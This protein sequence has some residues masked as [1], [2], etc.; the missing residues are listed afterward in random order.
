VGE[1]SGS[2]GGGELLIE[3]LLRVIDEG[4][5][6][7]TYKLALLAG[8]IDAVAMSP[9]ATSIPTRLVAERVLTLYYPQ[10][11]TYV[12]GDGVARDLRQI[13]MK[14]SP[15][16]RQV[17]RLR[18]AADTARCRTLDEA[19]TR[20]PIYD[21]VLD[22]VESTFVRYPIPLLQ[23][24]GAVVVPFLYEVDA[25]TLPGKRRVDVVGAFV[26]FSRLTVGQPDAPALGETSGWCLSAAGGLVLLGDRLRDPPRAGTLTP[27]L[28]AHSRSRVMS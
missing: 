24:V 12:A 13:S 1:G 2:V 16:L 19:R 26:T 3:R 6:T 5:R 11:R 20:L 14:T 18:E 4:R 15:V 22:D 10:T 27:L 23:V 7:A 17:T 28:S 21:E 8:L 25:A 9:G